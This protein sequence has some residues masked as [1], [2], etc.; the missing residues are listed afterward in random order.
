MPRFVVAVLALS[1][2][3][4]DAK[5]SEGV[6]CGDNNSC[7]SG[8]VCHLDRC[9]SMI[10]IDTVDPEGIDAPMNAAL[11]CADPGVF[12]T[13][14]G[15]AMATTM[16]ATSKM[17]SLC[18]GLVQNGPDRVYRITMNGSNM[19]RVTV[20]GGRKA[21][22][23]ASCMETPNTQACVGNV[24]ATMGNPITVTP[25]AGQAFVVVDDENAAASGAYTL[26][27]TIL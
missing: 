23:L 26:T 13:T 8:L 16:G 12:P 6:P 7:P 4:F 3:F 11:N 19:L 22:V 1:G 21:Y 27:L 10:P 15:Q 17:S 14:G 24:R 2:C 18:G 20:D 9:V 5:Y 25:A